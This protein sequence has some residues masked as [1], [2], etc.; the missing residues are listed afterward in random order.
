MT[1]TPT[2]GET[3][4]VAKNDAPTVAPTQVNTVD[5]AEVERLRKAAEQAQ[6]RVNQ[7]E[8]EAKKRKEADEAAKL[9]QLEENDEW[10]SLA[11][12]TKAKL[13]AYESE[14]EAEQVANQL[15]EARNSVLKDFPAEV[16]EIAEETGMSLLDSSD[17]AKEAFKAKLEKISAKVATTAKVTPNNPANTTP[18]NAD[19]QELLKRMANGDRQAR[20][21][22][23]SEIP[24]VKAMR[25]MAGYSE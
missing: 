15:R 14:R 6:M 18:P 19:K 13:E 10:K 2:S 20:T 8:N 22:V 25:K 24:G 9:K 1:D 5:P 7:L 23:I 11:E 12:Q 17:E 21:Q 3:V 16:V 4:V